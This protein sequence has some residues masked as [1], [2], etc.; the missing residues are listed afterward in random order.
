MLALHRGVG[1]GAQAMIGQLLQ[2][3]RKAENIGVREAARII[4]V[5][6]GTISRI[7]RGYPVDSAT[8]LLLINWL[9]QKAN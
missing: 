6:H 2:H 8:L 3:W 9:F 1:F 4:G 5:S 7:E